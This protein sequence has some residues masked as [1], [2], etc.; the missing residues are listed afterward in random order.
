MTD[1]RKLAF[2][3]IRNFRDFGGYAG[4]QGTLASGRLFR[5]GHHALASDAD[6]EKLEAMNVVAVI[7]LR[8]PNERAFAPSRRWSGF[9][10]TL[11]E[12]D[13]GH[14]GQES[15]EDFQARWDLTQESFR[16]HQHRYYRRAPFLPRL[17][18]LYTRAF[19]TLA[20]S[21]GPV[22]VHCAAGKDRTGVLVALIHALAG[23]HRDD[24]V[25]DYL[26]TN[27]PDWTDMASR[28]AKDIESRRGRAPDMDAMR[29]MIWV[30]ASYLDAAFAAITERHG[31]IEAYL[32]DALGVDARRRDATMRRLFG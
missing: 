14:E 23:V 9:R 29:A 7:D 2:D 28:W 10:A 16:D 25:A 22:I 20:T 15:W 19:E 26:L 30:D 24:I 27:D 12:N 17:N 11:I 4:A 6:L 21:D 3:G 8:R 18:D 13:D 1:P 32:R 5:S 31:S